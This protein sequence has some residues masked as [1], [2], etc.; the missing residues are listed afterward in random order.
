MQKDSVDQFN[1]FKES[2]PAGDMRTVNDERLAD[3]ECSQSWKRLETLT[4]I[5]NKET[6]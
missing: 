2:I 6:N 4:M 5:I 3:E 1:F